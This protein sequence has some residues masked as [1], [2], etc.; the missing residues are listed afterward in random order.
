[1]ERNLKS[2]IISYKELRIRD[3]LLLCLCVPLLTF[4]TTSVKGVTIT[5][6]IAQA[7]P[8]R[9]TNH[10]TLRIGSQGETVTELQSALKLLGYYTGTVDGDYNQST[11]TAVSVFQQAAGLTPDGIVG[12]TTWEKL[13]PGISSSD[14]N[15]NFPTPTQVSHQTEAVNSSPEPKPATPK[16]ITTE[17][18]NSSPEPKPTT[19]KKTTTK[20]NHSTPE[21][22][23]T[24]S[25][26][27]VKKQQGETLTSNTHTQQAPGLQYTSDG[28]PILRLRTH[29]PE[30]IKLQEKLE[31][32]GYLQGGIDGDFG[33]TTE[34]AVK[35]LQKHYGL[36]ADGVSGGA[37]WE[38][39]MHPPRQKQ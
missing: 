15:S 1:M 20:I 28:L 2:S 36:E 13:F 33:H 22:K 39:L 25:K 6:K 8:Q 9:A 21:T 38:I 32:L 26:T 31:K 14:S 16:K 3:W 35:A 12:E 34:D 4:F 10:P 17:V 23:P 7:S 24:L 5:Q 29:G 18:N 19:P 27:K 37:T 11:A 30:V